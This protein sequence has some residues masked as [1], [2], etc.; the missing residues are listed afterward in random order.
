MSEK[1]SDEINGI[2]IKVLTQDPYKLVNGAR[3]GDTLEE[4]YGIA[5]SEYAQNENLMFN[6]YRND[7][8]DILGDLMP[9]YA[10]YYDT[11]DFFDTL[12]AYG[13]ERIFVDLAPRAYL[14]E[15]FGSLDKKVPLCELYDQMKEDAKNDKELSYELDNIFEEYQEDIEMSREEENKN[16]KAR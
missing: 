16:K 1:M 2:A 10:D 4:I 13:A 5:S 12:D 14:K 9:L 8:E 6:F 7:F 15:K 3:A 11:K